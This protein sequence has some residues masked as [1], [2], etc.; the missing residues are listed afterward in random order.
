MMPGTYLTC[1]VPKMPSNYKI[2]TAYNITIKAKNTELAVCA[3][4]C[5]FTYLDKSPI[6]EPTIA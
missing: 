3:G 4:N 1:F 6:I 5:T 2:G